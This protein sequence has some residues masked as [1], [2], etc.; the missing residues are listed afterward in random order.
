MKVERILIHPNEC[1]R[2][3]IVE[4]QDGH[5][6]LYEQHRWPEEPEWTWASE[7]LDDRWA[8][9]EELSQPAKAWH[10]ITGVFANVEQAEEE[11]RSSKGFSSA[12]VIFG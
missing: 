9:D 4:R 3:A 1:S 6:V 11:A 10:L 2:I 12:S 8:S 5:F 7:I